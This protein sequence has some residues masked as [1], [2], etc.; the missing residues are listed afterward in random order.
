MIAILHLNQV[1]MGD[2]NFI[3]ALRF[4]NCSNEN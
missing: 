3:F 2:E 4:G 1:M